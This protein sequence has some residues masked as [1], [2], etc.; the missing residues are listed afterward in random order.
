MR[1]ESAG[2]AQQPRARRSQPVLHAP[3]RRPVPGRQHARAHLVAD[4]RRRHAACG[5]LR[6]PRARQRRTSS[7]GTKKDPRDIKILDPACGS[8]HFLLYAFDLLQTIYEEAWARRRAAAVVGR[9]RRDAAGGL[10]RPRDLH[11]AL[12]AL[13]LGHNLYGVDIDAARGA[14]RGA[15][16]LAAGAARLSRAPASQQTSRPSITRTHI[17]V[18]EPMPGDASSRRDVRCELQPPLL[19][20][21]FKRMVSEMRLAGELGTLLRVD[22]AIASS[23]TKAREEYVRQASEQATSR[24]S[25]R[26]GDRRSSTSPRSTTCASSRRPRRCCSTRFTASPS[27]RQV[28]AGLGAGS[29]PTTPLRESRSSSWCGTLRRRADESAL[30]CVL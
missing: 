23:L 3:L 10:R 11:R 15:G 5:A 24:G 30:R 27:R 2:A 28:G 19:G 14:D 9:H 18:A 20:E 22:D 16:A 26:S 8:G 4:A 1:D 17:V 13:I 12:P 21:L 25:S 6:V 29:S 7:C